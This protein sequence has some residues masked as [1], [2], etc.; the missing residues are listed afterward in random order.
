MSDAQTTPDPA[1]RLSA[2]ISHHSSQVAVARRLKTLLKERGIDGWL[3]PDDIAAGTAFDQAILDQI[4]RSDAI[5]LLFCAQSDQSR[6]VK[7][8][9]MLGEDGSKQ[10]L[11]VRLEDVPAQGLAYW[12]KDYQWIDWF[13]GE[14][15][16]VERIVAAM[17]GAV[18]SAPAAP[19]SR[20]PVAVKPW[21]RRPL[22]LGVG[23]L[24][25]AGLFAGGLWWTGGTSGGG[26]D[27]SAAVADNPIEPGI[28]TSKREVVKILFPEEIAPEYE[29]QFKQLMETDPDPE[30]CIGEKVAAKPDVEL[31]DPGKQSACT[32]GSFKMNG[33][34]IS[35]YLNCKI[36]GDPNGNL[37]VTV[38]GTYTRTSMEF[39]N[40]VTMQ[41]SQGMVR[42]RS[43]ETSK[44][45]RG[46][47]CMA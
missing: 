33:G 39:D 21:L 12:L 6:H 35:G 27:P 1:R 4:A 31:F 46:P 47:S 38:R 18:A 24:A 13:A 34:R 3:A 19:P 40:V 5:V 30:D 44:W 20:P 45:V 17:T 14:E 41:T 26:G 37:Q 15:Q 2:F 25:L 29:A 36:A 23:G 42:F 9:L 7:R 16:A 10:I 28:W 22:T 43:H 8:E 32:I 11:P